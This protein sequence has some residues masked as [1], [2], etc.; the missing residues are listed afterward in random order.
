M[1]LKDFTTYFESLQAELSRSREFEPGDLRIKQNIHNT[2][3]AGVAYYITHTISEN[4]DWLGNYL[5]CNVA[6]CT[7]MFHS[8]QLDFGKLLN[9][10]EQA[11]P[12]EPFK[13]KGLLLGLDI[14]YKMLKQHFEQS[15]SQN[16]DISALPAQTDD[17]PSNTNA[18]SLDQ[19]TDKIVSE[20]K[21]IQSKMNDFQ[22]SQ[23]NATPAAAIDLSSLETRLD[24]ICEAINDVTAEMPGDPDEVDLTNV[25][26][27]LTNIETHLSTLVSRTP[28]P[29]SDSENDGAN[30]PQNLAKSVEVLADKSTS[31]AGSTQQIAEVSASLYETTYNIAANLIALSTNSAVYAH[32]AQNVENNLSELTKTIEK[33]AE[34]TQKLGESQ[35]QDTTHTE[36]SSNLNDMLS[37]TA[38]CTLTVQRIEKALDLANTQ[39]AENAKKL[40]HLGNA[41]TREFGNSD[42]SDLVGAI[43]A[44][45]EKITEHTEQI[46]ASVQKLAENNEMISQN[47][48]QLS[49]KLAENNEMISQNIGQLSQKCDRMIR[50]LELLVV[51]MNQNTRSSENSRLHNSVSE[52]KKADD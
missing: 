26:K 25:E 11:S 2:D 15:G 29:K 18:L 16:A 6:N 8:I 5:S 35:G 3:L 50:A 20:L 47:I 44:N 12:D 14:F 46:A 37:H 36:I 39:L 38:L 1:N 27:K 40:E 32:T 42:V 19:N 10:T 45:T 17:L 30:A 52:L 21:Q 31:I 7:E 24:E 34:N 4:T 48:C 9:G 43:T 49:Q 41:P 23:T 13:Q 51:S 33:I 28:D 22:V